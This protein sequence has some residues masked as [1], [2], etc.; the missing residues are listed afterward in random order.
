MMLRSDS[1][2]QSSPR[3]GAEIVFLKDNVAIHPTQFASERISGRLK[4]IKQSSS[5]SMVIVGWFFRYSLVGSVLLFILFAC[6]LG[7]LTKCIVQRP[8]CLIKVVY[9]LDDFTALCNNMF[10]MLNFVL[11]SCLDRNLYTIRAVPFTD[12]RSIRRHNPAFGWQY[13]IVVLSSGEFLLM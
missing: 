9:I 5:L 13:V 4:L 6:R 12:I 1:A 3:E 10:Y 11:F 2:K 7:Y 8:G